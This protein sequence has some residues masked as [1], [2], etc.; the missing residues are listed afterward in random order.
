MAYGA[1]GCGGHGDKSTML[2]NTSWLADHLKDPNLVVI[3]VGQQKEYDAGHIPGSLFMQFSDLS[4][5]KGPT[6]LSLEL[7][8]MAELVELFGKMGVTNDSRIILY[9]TK[10][11][12]S[13]TSRV[14][15]TLDA[16]GLGAR[17][18]L[19]DGG[20]PIWQ[21]EGRQV[22]TE[23]PVVKPGKL[24][25]CAQNDVIVDLDYIRGNLHHPG[26]DLLDVRDSTPDAPFYS[27]DKTAPS[28]EQVIQR[29]GHIPGARSLP[30]ELLLNDDGHLK[31]REELQALFDGA[32]VKRGDRVVSYCWVGQRATFVYFVA[33]Y[34]G[35][36]ARLYDGSWEEWNKHTELPT[37][38]SATK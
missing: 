32:G 7:L 23:V 11:W 25:L 29:T 21:K 5:K 24:E 34:L 4:M 9:E 12:F 30:F 38:T 15:L 16:M 17:T 8:P 2:V 20:F 33:R 35:Y 28:H 6:G 22:S 13:P 1:V 36:D 37:E 3:G 27:G 14:Y 10:D 31:P 26:V 19:L 18:S